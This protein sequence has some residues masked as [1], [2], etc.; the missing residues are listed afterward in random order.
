M[1]IPCSNNFAQIILQPL[2]V[3]VV[4]CLG[5]PHCP[6]RKLEK[7]TPVCFFFN[8]FKILLGRSPLKISVGL[9]ISLIKYGFFDRSTQKDL[10]YHFIFKV[11]LNIMA[12]ISNVIFQNAYI[13]VTLLHTTH[14][15]VKYTNMHLCICIYQGKVKS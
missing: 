14:I 5:K 3:S 4:S 13:T 11:W 12:F 10:V 1:K 6:G 7:S 8:F 2:D 15:L 9:W